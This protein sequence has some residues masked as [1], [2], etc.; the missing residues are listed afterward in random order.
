[1]PQ[2]WLSGLDRSNPSS[3]ES[4]RGRHSRVVIGEGEVQPRSSSIWVQEMTRKMPI[5]LC[6]NGERGRFGRQDYHNHNAGLKG[7]S[8]LRIDLR[9]DEV[10]MIAVLEK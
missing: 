3:S 2:M 6:E 5:G 1:M 4:Q 8:R 10:S 7:D 9:M